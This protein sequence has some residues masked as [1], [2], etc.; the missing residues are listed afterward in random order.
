M[1]DKTFIIAE[2]GVNHNGSLDLGLRL[3]EAAKETGA[4]AVKFQTFSADRLVTRQAEKAVYQKQTTPT[5][6][7]QYRML[8]KLELGPGDH[9]FL[10]KRAKELGIIFLSSPFDPEGADLLEKLD[11][12]MIKI[13]SGEITN[14]PLI[15]HIARM[16]K[17]V[18]LSTG[19]ST[20][21]EIEEAIEIIYSEGNR[22]V[23][24]LH[25]VTEY[26]APFEQ[27][28]LRAI[29]TLKQAF[30]VPV[31]YSDH[32]PG[33]EIAMAAVALGA[34]MIE[35]HFTLDRT[36]EGPDHRASLEP[37]EL[38]QMVTAIRNIEKALGDGIK[39]PAPCELKNREIA[40]KSVV[41]ACRIN[42]GEKITLDKVTMKRP[43]DGIAPRDLEKILGLAVSR[44]VEADEPL[45]WDDLQ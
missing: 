34:E 37:S 22:G 42:P 39:K 17:P 3:I 16:R 10:L 8:K 43:G 2:A 28:N 1:K 12:P 45:R 5:A 29:Q 7:S 24:L 9:A 23:T 38:K 19:M 15:R 27:I 21:G 32:S 41:A 6:E 18:I 36:L 11:V 35:K 31:G 44:V 40:R 14:H 33:T 25:C 13:P 20:L 4:D 30:K 26:P